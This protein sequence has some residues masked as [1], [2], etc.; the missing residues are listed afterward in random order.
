MILARPYVLEL[1]NVDFSVDGSARPEQFGGKA[2]APS[3][4]RHDVAHGLDQMRMQ[5]TLYSHGLH[6]YG[7]YSYGLYSHR[8]LQSYGL[9]IYGIYACGPDGYGLR[10]SGLYS[11]GLSLESTKG[12]CR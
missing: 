1:P 9:Y 8:L 5:A 11:D 10:S 2:Q 6:S 12:G 4:I 7:L 3:G